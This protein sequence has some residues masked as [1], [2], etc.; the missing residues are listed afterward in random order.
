MSPQSG[1]LLAYRI[2]AWVVGVLLI[3]LVFV[4]VPLKYAADTPG[5]AKW[6]GFAH[7]VFAYPIY[8]VTTVV[9]AFRTRMPV[10]RALLTLIAGT[11]PIVSFVAE[12]KTTT[13]V[14]ARP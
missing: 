1:N 5:I 11:I 9:L 2:I 4:G 10:V 8:L 3:V 7:G 6:V 12:R 13:W 14:R